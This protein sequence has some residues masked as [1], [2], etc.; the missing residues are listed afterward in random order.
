MPLSQVGEVEDED[1]PSSI[2]GDANDGLNRH[3]DGYEPPPVEAPP[4]H[5]I[6]VMQGAFEESIFEST[7]PE[8]LPSAT[9]PS[10]SMRVGSDNNEIMSG[11]RAR[12]RQMLEKDDYSSVASSRLSKKP[13]AKYHAFWKL[14]AQISF[15]IHLLHDQLAKSDEEVVKIMQAHVDEIDAF[16]ERTTEDFDLAIADIGE[17]INFLKLPLEHVEI[18]EAML[19]DKKFCTSI[20]EGNDK[21]ETIVNRTARAMNESLLDIAKG[22]E[23]TSELG[24]Y[25]DAL[26]SQWS[27]ENPEFL[28][29]Y[30]AMRGN[31]E[32]WYRCFRRL[33]LK[34]SSLGV[35][36]VQLGSMLTEMS[37]RAGLV[38]R[39][40]SVSI[41]MALNLTHMY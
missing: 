30:T 27:D 5:P 21:I 41:R 2:D 6:P 9:S 17:R 35:L 1:F 7:Q 19:E 32:G 22:L 18:F 13:G 11:A 3:F 33:Q 28:G 38:G 26:G 29:I 16:L 24:K 31:T 12:R 8:E 34:G 25:L 4:M 23:A 15:G 14:A 40:G 37:K 20:M 10:H 36:L 39:K